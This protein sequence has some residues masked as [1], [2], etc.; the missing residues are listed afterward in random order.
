[1]AGRSKTIPVPRS[2]ELVSQQLSRLKTFMHLPRVQRY[3]VA[4]EMGVSE[5]WLYR[6]LAGKKQLAHYQWEGLIAVASQYCPEAS[7][8]GLLENPMVAFSIPRVGPIIKS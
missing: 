8:V 2:A 6:A 3:L 7:R 4:K 5:V 1:M